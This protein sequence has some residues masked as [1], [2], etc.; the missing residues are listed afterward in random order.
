MKL[1]AET[2]QRFWSSIERDTDSGCWIWKAWLRPDG[3]GLFS[4]KGKAY[5]ASRI[6]WQIAN[7]DI[8]K[9]LCV[10]HN[11]PQGDN[12]ACINPAHLFLGTRQENT[13]DMLRKNRSAK[14]EAHSHA[15]LTEKEV[16]EIRQLYATGTF[17]QEELGNAYGVRAPLV[18]RI[19]S[20]KIWRHI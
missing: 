2:L 3:Y 9:G 12:P 6:S 13:K 10:L 16:R 20:R 4:I 5:R 15:K 11:C 18:S 8:P 1:D 19:V 14:G 7:G 17:S